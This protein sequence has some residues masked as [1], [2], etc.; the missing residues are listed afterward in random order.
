MSGVAYRAAASDPT[1]YPEEERV[2]EELLRRWIAELLRPL[3]E[4]WLAQ[5]GVAALVGADQFIYYEQ[6]NPHKRL[7]PDVY[8]LPGV[9]PQTRVRAW[10]LWQTGIAP[11]FAFE[12]VSTDWEKDYV[13]TPERAAEAGISELVIF[14]PGWAERPGGAGAR[15][16]IYRRAGK[17]GLGRIVTTNED[18][19]RSRSLGCWLR[20]V[21]FGDAARV[22]LGT[23]VRGEHLVPTAEEAERAAKEVERAAKEVALAETEAERAAK[24]A[25]LADR[26]VERA[27]REAERAAKE[28]ER[29]AKQAALERVAELEAE[30]R[31]LR[32]RRSGR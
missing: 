22:R 1:V 6:H 31:R 26:E 28:A 10:K 7:A 21:G 5:R 4:R 16:Q 11:S 9:P 15:W 12:V 17:R 27:A 29:A 25:A 30:L 19:V 3:V 14:D 20:A 8:V 32:R 18:R 2:G 23:G 13:E 24:E